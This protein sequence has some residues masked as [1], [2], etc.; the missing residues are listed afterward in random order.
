M[1]NRQHIETFTTEQLTNF[2][3]FVA[4]KIGKMYTQSTTGLIEFYNAEYAG[5]WKDFL[6]NEMKNFEVYNAQI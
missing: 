4:P 5:W 6:D 2:T 3:L 1:T